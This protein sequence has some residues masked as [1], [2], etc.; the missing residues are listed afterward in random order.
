MEFTAAFTRVDHARQFAERLINDPGMWVADVKRVGKTVTFVDDLPA[1][2]TFELN[3]FRTDGEEVEFVTTHPNTATSIER[4]H[5]RAEMVGYYGSP[6]EGPV[7]TL[8]G[9]RTPRSY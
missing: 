4:W 9:I 2:H 7:A 3:P 1:D 6:P 8:N 5:D